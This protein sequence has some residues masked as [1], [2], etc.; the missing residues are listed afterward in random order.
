MIPQ[1]SRDLSATEVQGTLDS[2]LARPEFTPTEPPLL[3]RLLENVSDWVSARLWPLLSRLLPDPDWSSPAWELAGTVLFL[4]GALVGAALLAY[5]AVI[6]A[7]A[8][9]ARS[10]R[11]ATGSAGPAP[12]PVTA[13]D[14]ET[15]A[16]GAAAERDWRAAALALYQ[17]VVLRLGER[18]I[19]RVDRAK[20]PGDYR[21]E[22]KRASGDVPTRVEGFLAGFE[23]VA[24]GR[25]EPGPEQYDHLR[26]HARALGARA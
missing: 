25:S 14:W 26:S 6:G 3:Y 5:L 9:R 2:V 17:A 23:R 24:Y 21:R 16:A 12:G 11:A 13:A 10:R 15:V 19:V 1:R 7:R 4:V 22:A 20:T 8:W 18:G